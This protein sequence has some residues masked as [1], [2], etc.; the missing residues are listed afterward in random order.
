MLPEV[1]LDL[2]RL[3]AQGYGNGDGREIERQKRDEEARI[4]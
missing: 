4:R 3:Q 1:P 2:A